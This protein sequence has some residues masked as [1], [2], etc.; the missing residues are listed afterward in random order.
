MK[1]MVRESSYTQPQLV[2]D[3]GLA[4]VVVSNLQEKVAGYS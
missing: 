3:Q 1:N 2:W 4:V